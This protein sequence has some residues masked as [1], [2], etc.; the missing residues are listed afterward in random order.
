[1]EQDLGSEKAEEIQAEAVVEVVADPAPEGAAAANDTPAEPIALVART[2]SGDLRDAMIELMKDQRQAW[3]KLSERQQ[4][5]VAQRVQDR[6]VELVIDA[7]NLIAAHGF[8]AISVTLEQ[9]TFK[10][11]GIEAK[12]AL[13]NISVGTRHALVDAQGSQVM[14]VVAD[15]K[16]FLGARGA[17]KI[18]KQALFDAPPVE[19]DEAE[20]D[21]VGPLF[22]G[23]GGDAADDEIPGAPQVIKVEDLPAYESEARRIGREDGQLGFRD[24]AARYASGEPGH[25]DYELGH[26][27]G[28]AER[29]ALEAARDHG[30]EAGT[31]GADKSTNPYDAGT[32]E[33]DQ[34]LAGWIAPRPGESGDAEVGEEQEA[35]KPRRGRRARAEAVVS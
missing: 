34:W 2:L 20:G 7:V 18:D 30:A 32:A 13:A 6:C 28:T 8:I 11:K 9:V 22:V 1:M 16:T 23:Q 19:Q 31:A 33:H 35:P 26:N 3:H 25:A 12:L 15:P 21:G 17:P 27:D 5:Y 24:H 14:I 4:E 29:R 10:P